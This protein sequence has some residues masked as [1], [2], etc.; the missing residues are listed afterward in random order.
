MKLF[1][2]VSILFASLA[3]VMGAGLV[4]SNDAKEVKAST[5]EFVLDGS[6]LS[7]TVTAAD[8]EF[9]IDGV[10]YVFSKGA[11]KQ[12]SSGTNKFS[13]DAILIGK[14]GTYIYNKTPLSGNINSFKIYANKGASTRV[15]IGVAFGESP[16]VDA[17]KSYAYTKT[18][19]NVDTIY[20]ATST[21]PSSALYF[22]YQVTNANNSQ[23]QFKIGVEVTKSVESISFKNGDNTSIS[24]LNLT[25]DDIFEDLVVEVLPEDASNKNLTWTTT[26]ED[27]Y[28]EDGAVYALAVGEATI[29]A[30]DADGSNVSNSFTVSVTEVGAP[31]LKSIE[32]SGELTK[33]VQYVGQV[34]DVTGLTFTPVYDKANSKPETITAEDITWPSLEAGMT[35]ITGR[36]KGIDVVVVGLTVEED[37]ISSLTISESMKKTSYYAGEEWDYTGLVVKANYKSGKESIDVTNDV[38]WSADKAPADCNIGENIEI[39]ITA[40]LGDVTSTSSMLVNITEVPPMAT[41]DF[42]KSNVGFD[43]SSLLDTPQKINGIEVKTIANGTTLSNSIQNPIR[44][45]K[46][47]SIEF[48]AKENIKTIKS[49]KVVIDTSKPINNTLK[50]TVSPSC[51]V[52]KTSDDVV[53]FTP[54]NNTLKVTMT[55]SEDQARWQ[56]VEVLYEKDSVETFAS[57][58]AAMRTD[59]GVNGICEFLKSGTEKRDTL[60]Y[61]LARFDNLTNSDEL[62]NYNDGDSQTSIL[63][64]INYVKNI[65]KGEQATDGD[66][67][68]NSGVIIT[69]NYSIDSTSLIALFALLG[70]G[71]ISAYYFIE[72]KKLSK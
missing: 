26:N 47:S 40:R 59:G 51:D 71:A 17:P 46:N 34:F 65:I 39:K 66:Y 20:D 53:T 13:D 23:I 43:A 14:S 33:K 3:L 63:D 19:N 49:I 60:D 50:A 54:N 35:S 22:R 29:T 41:F 21:L 2:K 67:G 58:W 5:K 55:F 9:T 31:V 12:A 30:T 36:Y 25:K 1:N 62:A 27:I 28:Y 64:S 11:K 45:Y 32:V 70:I 8:T 57:E 42:S 7:S 56:S 52:S 61:M 69:S 24:H 37:G 6:S 44:L 15:S 48:S 38:V 4:G 68:I 10:T 72:K 16:I 18:L